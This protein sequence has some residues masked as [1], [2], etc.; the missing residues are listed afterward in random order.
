MRSSASVVIIG[1][2]A[3]G[4]SIAY[5]LARMGASDIALL[6]QNVIAWGST[7]RCAAGVREQ[8]GTE[9]NCRLSKRSLGILENLEE[10]L[11]Y[12]G[13]IELIQKGYLILA[14]TGREWEQ[15]RKNVSLQNSHGIPSQCITPQEAHDIVPML[16][17]E[18]LLGATFCSTDG[19]CNPFRLTVAYAEAA[20]R[21]GVQINTRTKVTG[22]IMKGDRVAGVRTNKGDIEADTVICTAGPY[23]QL[24]GEMA[25][26]SPPNYAE[27]HQILVT[28]P[29]EP[30]QG[31]MVISF[32]RRFYC[33]QTPHGSF[34]MGMGDPNERKSYDIGHSW[35]FLEETARVACDI[36]PPLKDLCV[37][38]QWSGLY[39]MTPDSQP[40]LGLVPGVEGMFI[41]SGW[42]GHGLMMAPVTGVLLA[43]MVLG[44]PAS[45][46]VSM[47]D[48]GRFERGD[49]VMEPS[50]V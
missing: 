24:I 21:L 27:R 14:Y 37:V 40:V 28:E 20:Q 39:D 46:D 42:S 50:V 12:S 8:W 1:G 43:E 47:L 15:F 11:E 26:V 45:M 6:E 13:D 9:I 29:V 10:E 41:A 35:Q 3:M 2:G 5:N 30:L 7:G 23:S 38:R 44:M 31:P 32:S 34:V 25:G 16:N 36:M 22:L 17:T 33:Q 19:H 18:G 48:V 49:L 4:S